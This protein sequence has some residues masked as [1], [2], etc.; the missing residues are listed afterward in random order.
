M[1]TNN[2]AAASTS[3]AT[4]DEAVLAKLEQAVE[5]QAGEEAGTETADVET[6]NKAPEAGEQPEYGQAFKEL[7]DK[8]GFKNVDDLVRSYK[9]VESRSTKAEQAKS[10]LETQISQLQTMDKK[11]QLN[12]EQKQALDTLEATIDKVLSKKLAPVQEA[13]GVQKV[14]RMVADLKGQYSDFTGAV[15]DETLD[16]MLSNPRVSMEDAYKIVSWDQVKAGGAKTQA[17]QQKQKEKSR[18]Y[19]EGANTAKGGNDLDYSKLSLEELEEI[20]P[21]SGQFIDHRGNMRR[22]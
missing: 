12:D 15:V 3:Q 18:A 8:K 11:G 20:L 1:E 6:Q 7:A 2:Q 16:Y 10:A 4:S 17:T 13:L 9:A 14:D 21:S 5:A 19:V 22:G